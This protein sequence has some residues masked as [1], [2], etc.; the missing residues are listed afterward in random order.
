M[1]SRTFFLVIANF[2]FLCSNI[3]EAQ[4]QRP[5]PAREAHFLQLALD[6]V[7]R[8]YPNKISHVLQSDSDARTPRELHPASQRLNPSLLRLLINVP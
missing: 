1:L 3:A 5:E 4:S 8:E 2:A 7:D 6:C